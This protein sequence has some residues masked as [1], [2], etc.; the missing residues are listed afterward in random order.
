MTGSDRPRGPDETPAVPADKPDVLSNALQRTD[1]EFNGVPNDETLI[2]HD[3]P[4]D[5]EDDRDE[6]DRREAEESRAGAGDK[7]R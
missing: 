2:G 4:E 6:I 1:N 3:I 7:A 5:E